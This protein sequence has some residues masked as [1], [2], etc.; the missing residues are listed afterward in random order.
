MQKTLDLIAPADTYIEGGTQTDIDLNCIND[1]GKILPVK[2]SSVIIRIIT[3]DPLTFEILT[4]LGEDQFF[5]VNEDESII[6]PATKI[7]N[8]CTEQTVYVLNYI[9]DI[10]PF[11]VCC[12][13]DELPGNIGGGDL[14]G[15]GD[16]EPGGPNTP[17]VENKIQFIVQNDEDNGTF[18]N[19]RLKFNS[20]QSFN[21]IWGDGLT[22]SF[23]GS[24]NYSFTHIFNTAGLYNVSIELNNE[25][26]LQELQLDDG[27]I[28][29]I[30]GLE[31]YS[32]LEKLSLNN[33]LLTA[34]PTHNTALTELKVNANKIADLGTLSD[35]LLTVLE[36]AANLVISLDLPTTLQRLV[37]S[38]NP[39]LLSLDLSLLTTLVF[40][41][42][43]NCPAIDTI[44][45]MQN[46]LVEF[47]AN[48]CA[49]ASVGTISNI[50]EV[51]NVA[52]N[53]LDAS[54]VDAIITEIEGQAIDNGI[55]NLE[56]QTPAA[57]PTATTQVANL[58]GRGWEVTTD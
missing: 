20:I 40:V 47:Y 7:Y 18:I 57:V 9:N 6:L 27:H 2:L 8:P 56:D 22:S 14:P 5:G 38:G 55:L 41:D 3:T 25:S 10:A 17:A 33:N 50:L 48:S 1:A 28:T 52:D 21:V 54:D 42:I 32:S 26:S 24:N 44:G 11:I 12:T 49:I 37:A 15:G 23:S 46:T 30:S 35:M 29:G 51:L 13:G 53:V 34:L 31:N 19:C 43:S 58:I 45:N 16:F 36:C 39:N 4:Q